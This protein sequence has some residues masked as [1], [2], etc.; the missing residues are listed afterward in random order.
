MK[1]LELLTE[2]IS[3]KEATHSYTA[4]RYGIDNTPPLRC[5]EKMR[6]VAQVIFE[7]LRRAMG[8][9][10]AINS[11][12]RSPRLNR[13][14]GGARNSQHTRCEAIDIDDTL[15]VKYGITNRD[16]FCWLYRNT[17]FDQLIWEYG[18]DRAP[19]WVHVSYKPSGRNRRQVLRA[20]R[21]GKRTCYRKMYRDE[22]ERLCSLAARGGIA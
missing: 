9:P 12:Y 16:F 10:I 2:H 13:L 6:R 7:P 3:L 17:P 18:T 15:S 22:I 21:C 11:F 20:Y 4:Q 1:N 14:L 19:A 8:V 5:I